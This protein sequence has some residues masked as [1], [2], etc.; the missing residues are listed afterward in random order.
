M[1]L[2][3]L[4]IV[5]LAGYAKA[6]G[7]VDVTGTWVGNALRGAATMTM[8]LHQTGNKVTGTL[9]GAGTADGPIDG[10][11]DG[12]TIRF[13]FDD[14][15]GDTPLLYVKGNEITGMLSGTTITLRRVNSAS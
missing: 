14:S 7:P 15:Y 13:R 8:V 12:D 3:V 4:S 6:E 9:T 11:V 5:M 2:M 1:V 10:V